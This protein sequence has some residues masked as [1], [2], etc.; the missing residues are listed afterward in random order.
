MKGRHL[1]AATTDGGS[2]RVGGYNNKLKDSLSLQ[3]GRKGY[4]RILMERFNLLGVGIS[5]TNVIGCMLKTRFG[6]LRCPG[7]IWA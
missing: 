3:R 7:S 5:L 1:A 2:F 6:F 4:P